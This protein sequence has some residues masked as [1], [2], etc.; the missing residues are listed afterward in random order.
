MFYEEN[1]SPPLRS[2]PERRNC[3]MILCFGGRAFRLVSCLVLNTLLALLYGL[4]GGAIAEIG[5]MFCGTRV[6]VEALFLVVETAPA[7]NK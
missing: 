7:D 3:R 6:P 5:R 1:L 4:G 2:P